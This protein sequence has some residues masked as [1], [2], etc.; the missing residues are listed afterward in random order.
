[1]CGYPPS[2]GCSPVGPERPAKWPPPRP[3]E[4]GGL[5]HSCGVSAPSPPR[6]HLPGVVEAFGFDVVSLLIHH[7]HLG[8][9]VP[10][11]VLG[12]GM[13]RRGTFGLRA[14]PGPSPLGG[15]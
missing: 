15:G 2:A 6:A 13:E 9:Q 3:A 14:R 11:E 7:L 10:T 8:V 1:M 4:V 12:A 5:V